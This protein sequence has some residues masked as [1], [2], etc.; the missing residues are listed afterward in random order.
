M[1]VYLLTGLGLFFRLKTRKD[2]NFTRST[3]VHVVFFGM[4]SC[5]FCG[6]EPLR[7]ANFGYSFF[8]NPVGVFCAV[9][10]LFYVRPSFARGGH[11]LLLQGGFSLVAL[12][13]FQTTLDYG[14]TDTCGAPP[15]ALF[16]FVFAMLLLAFFHMWMGPVIAGFNL[17]VA[18]DLVFFGSTA[19][20]E[21]WLS[22]MDFLGAQQPWLR[23]GI[24]GVSTLLSLLSYLDRI[25][26]GSLVAVL[27]EKLST[28]GG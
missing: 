27:L 6:L 9:F 14:L 18:L 17:G 19:S 1:F 26:A 8:F 24:L 11:D 5:Y 25:F 16:A 22:V 23:W 3:L 28:L 4:A 2:L 15:L 10:W 13:A 20:T 12:L 7:A 21:G